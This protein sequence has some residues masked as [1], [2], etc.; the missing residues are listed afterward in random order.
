M[1]ACALIGILDDGLDGIFPRHRS[2]ET[3]AAIIQSTFR[4]KQRVDITTLGDP[5]EAE[6]G[7]SST[8]LIG[9]S[10][11]CVKNGLMITPWGYVDKYGTRGARS[12]A[13]WKAGW[14]RSGRAER[15][16]LNWRKS[17]ISPRTTS[18]PYSR[19]RLGTEGRAA[20]LLK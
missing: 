3:P 2:P 18:L 13:V 16:P 12:P 10:N 8:V 6:I 20:A 4:P 15:R 17:T 5:A 9:N 11:I 7:M 19:K 1:S 14:W